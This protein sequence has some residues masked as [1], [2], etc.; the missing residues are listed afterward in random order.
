MDIH[1]KKV[2]FQHDITFFW[3]CLLFATQTWNTEGNPIDVTLIKYKIE[4]S[5][6]LLNREETFTEII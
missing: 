6:S 5:I 4:E 1:I 3:W 2:R